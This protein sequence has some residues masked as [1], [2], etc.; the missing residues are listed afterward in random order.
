MCLFLFFMYS[1]YIYT[2]RVC[3]VYTDVLYIHMYAYDFH[4]SPDEFA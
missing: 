2:H 1:I 3:V 4:L